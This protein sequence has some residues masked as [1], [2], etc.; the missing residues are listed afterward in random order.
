MSPWL[1]LVVPIG[2]IV[3]FGIGSI[4]AWYEVD[5]RPARRAEHR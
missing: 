1:L 4:V 3:A 5:V 2:I